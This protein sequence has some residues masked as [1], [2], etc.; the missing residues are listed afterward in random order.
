MES[1]RSYKHSAPN[2]AQH[3]RSLTAHQTAEPWNT[4]KSWRSPHSLIT[5]HDL[6][7]TNDRI[8]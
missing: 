7:N 3:Q 1:R 8:R 2:G 4:P 6:I 5:I